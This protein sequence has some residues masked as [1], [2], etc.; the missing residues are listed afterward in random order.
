MAA[1]SIL[2]FLLITQVASGE[3]TFALIVEDY[4]TKVYEYL[5]PLLSSSGPAVQT[6]N[7]PF[8]IFA[9]GAAQYNINEIGATDGFTT[10]LV[11]QNTASLPTTT[12]APVAQ[13]PAV[14]SSLTIT[15]T[16]APVPATNNSPAP[17]IG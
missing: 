7:A 4:I 6:L 12:P 16:A 17:F 1:L 10:Y 13:P 8:V 14:S 11:M 15:T 3:Y 5:A 9:T 2:P